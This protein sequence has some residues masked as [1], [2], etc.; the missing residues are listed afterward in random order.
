VFG[1]QRFYRDTIVATR[2]FY[3]VLRVLQA[4]EGPT[5]HRSLVHG[6]ILHGTQYLAPALRQQPTTYYTATS[7]VGRLLESMHPRLRPLKVGVIGLGT[8]TLAAWGSKGDT[9]RFYDINP[10]VPTLA[11]TEFSYLADSEATIEIALGDARLNLEREA[12]QNFDLLA[13]DAFS[14]DAIP[15][16]LITR[17]ALAVYLRHVRP[18]G[19]IAF[20]V[21]NRFLNLVPVVEALAH[22]RNLHVVQVVDDAERG[23]ASKSD[24]VLVAQ[25]SSLL[26]KPLIA[27]ATRPIETRRDWRVW[28]DDFNNL[29]QVLR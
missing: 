17:E 13:V 29:L 21:T 16:H 6:T 22:E 19:V 25:D 2:N 27:E 5:L 7:G 24:W 3:G 18:D 14:S 8:G 20:H 1:M 9:Y 11:R 15:V 12:A 4:G 23:F 26:D 10:A 28:T